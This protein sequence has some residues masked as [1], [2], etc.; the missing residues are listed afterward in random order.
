MRSLCVLL[1]LL[2]LVFTGSDLRAQDKVSPGQCTCLPSAAQ[3]TAEQY[4]A[5]SI[6]HPLR[7]GND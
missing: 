3:G 1:A 2:S 5:I 6:Y 7:W 4:S